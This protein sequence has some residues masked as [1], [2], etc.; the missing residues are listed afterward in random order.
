MTRRPSSESAVLNR[1]LRKVWVPSGS[2]LKLGIG[3]DCAIFRPRVTRE[4]LLFTTDLLLEDIHFRRTTHSAQ[5]I[6]Y[7]ALARGLSDIAAMGAAPQFCLLSLAI[8]A[9]ADRAWVDRFYRGFLDLARATATP[10]AGG[11]LARAEKFACDVIVCGAVP[12]GKA[13]LRS[14]ARPGNAIYVSGELG[15][16]ALGL[17]S[18]RGRAWKRHLRPQPRLALGQWIRELGATAAM[19]LSDGLSLDLTRMCIA[20]HVAAE[21]APPP[22]FPGASL[23]QALHGGEDYE[24]LFTMPPRRRTPSHFG[25]LPLTRIGTIVRGRP[26]VLRLE[27]K[28]LKPLGFDHF[29]RA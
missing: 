4:D 14:G 7:K 18:G 12:R 2:S 3:D 8:P 15:G 17:S 25:G 23:D 19:D 10:L 16:S 20:S 11:D 29:Q 26:G 13:L 24:L 6:G 9:W 27:G 1:I 21:I 22:I 5:D 28:L